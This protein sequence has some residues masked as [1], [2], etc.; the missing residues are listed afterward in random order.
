[1]RGGQRVQIFSA[2]EAANICGVVNQTAIN[3]IRSGHLKAFNTPGG[4]Y[5][6]YAKDLADFLDKRGMTASLQALQQIMVSI[7]R[8]ILVITA[9]EQVCIKLKK[10]ISGDA[11]LNTF[12]LTEARSWFEAGLKMAAEKPG[13][14]LLDSE[15]NGH[16]IQSFIKT[17]KNEPAF[18]KP[19]IFLLTGG[20][21]ETV[22]RVD[23]VS[24]KPLEG[25]K[26]TIALKNILE[27]S[28]PEETSGV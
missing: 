13:F 27:H 23:M 24:K 5:R 20:Q 28:A 25:E 16:D 11:L 17:V 26:L 19:Y 7:N 4:Q 9:D 3:W 12:T 15:L 8:I 1:M 22:K 21:K 18:G 2:L 6:V 14:I 10:E